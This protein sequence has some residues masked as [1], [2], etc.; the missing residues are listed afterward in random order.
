MF[1]GRFIHMFRSYCGK[2]WWLFELVDARYNWC[3]LKTAVIHRVIGE[4]SK[5]SCV[6]NGQPTPVL[7]G[8]VLHFYG[9]YAILTLTSW[10]TGRRAAGGVTASDE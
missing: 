5:D 6:G 7:Q 1:I 10:Q 4:R 8:T 2:I 9:L 3:H